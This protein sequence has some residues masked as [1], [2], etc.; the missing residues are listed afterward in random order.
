VAGDIDGERAARLLE[1]LELERRRLER[2]VDG[3]RRE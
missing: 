3:F 1:E 2:P